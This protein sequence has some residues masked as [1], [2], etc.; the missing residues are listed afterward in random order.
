[1]TND[2]W[3]ANNYPYRGVQLKP[4]MLAELA[5]NHFPA[6]SVMPR[7]W[8]VEVGPRIHAELGGAPTS[9]D[10]VA[11]AKKA[12]STLLEGG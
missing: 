12:R 10:P 5:E 8:L 7:K 4:H 2:K 9:A 1:M 6:G 3:T 11:Q